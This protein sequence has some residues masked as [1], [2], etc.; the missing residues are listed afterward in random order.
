MVGEFRAFWTRGL[1]QESERTTAL[2]RLLSRVCSTSFAAVRA[3]S[4]GPDPGEHG[5][6]LARFLGLW[7]PCR[8]IT[9]GVGVTFGLDTP[10][11]KTP[12]LPVE[13]KRWVGGSRH[14]RHVEATWDQQAPG[15]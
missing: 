9:E 14:A 12:W 4:A 11:L 5:S 7:A 13:G 6:P 10:G 3:A 15:G 1:R 8:R 2:A